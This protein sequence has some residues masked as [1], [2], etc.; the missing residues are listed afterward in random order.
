MEKKKTTRE[1]SENYGIIVGRLNKDAARVRQGL[2]F[3]E[4][5]GR[6]TIFSVESEKKLVQ[7]IEEG[8]L[9]KTTKEFNEKLTELSI[10]TAKSRELGESTVGKISKRSVR[11]VEKRLNL[12][13]EN[14]N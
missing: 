8:T 11:R 2:P 4:S 7:Y 9:K 12:Q 14:V 5:N 6:P 13:S 10:E 3:C 1:L